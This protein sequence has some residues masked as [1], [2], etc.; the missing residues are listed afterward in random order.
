MKN[1]NELDQIVESFLQPKKSTTLGLKELFALF[2]EAQKISE[3]NVAGGAFLPTVDPSLKQYEKEEKSETVFY[4]VLQKVLT[5]EVLAKSEGLEAPQ[6]IKELIL[7]IEKL[8]DKDIKIESATLSGTFSTILFTSSLHKMIEDILPDNPSSA[9]FFFEKFLGFLLKGKVQTGADKDKL[10]IYDVV[11]DNPQQY[12]SMK[13]LKEFG[14]EGSIGNI[15]KYFTSSN[16]PKQ[17][18]KYDN[19]FNALDENGNIINADKPIIYIVTVKGLHSLKFYSYKF[20]V[21]QFL[22]ML[23]PEKIERYNNNL[24]FSKIRDSLTREID[25]L[26]AQI[27][28]MQGIEENREEIERLKD[29]QLDLLQQLN[30]LQRSGASQF[31]LSQ[32]ALAEVGAETFLKGTKEDTL[33]LSADAKQS[34]IE[35]Y[36]SIFKE[37]IQL[38][39]KESNLVYYKVNNF[40][41]SKDSNANEAYESVKLLEGHLSKYVS[42]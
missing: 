9:G 7:F 33:S 28:T 14:L 36:N 34:I 2:E 11:I 30:D 1:N 10:A 17:V 3:V 26:K 32:K 24:Q 39:I 38:I 27:D 16:N 18:I 37:D 13:L 15:Y 25:Q 29:Q 19:N 8:K 6:R 23:G 41:L 4:E 22:K 35:R 40:I 31:S 21:K 20:N 5:T 42:K 12:V